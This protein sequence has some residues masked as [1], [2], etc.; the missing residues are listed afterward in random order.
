MNK[1]T[2]NR[3]GSEECYYTNTIIDKLKTK[4]KAVMQINR[5]HNNQTKI[6]PENIKIIKFMY[7]TTQPGN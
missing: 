5:Q 6:Y 1:D 2:S 3:K 7:I 4:A